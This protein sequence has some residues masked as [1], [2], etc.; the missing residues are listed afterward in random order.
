MKG[1]KMRLLAAVLC[2]I[3]AVVWA[4]V[5]V[6]HGVNGSP[7]WL[8]GLN[9]LCTVIWCAACGMQVAYWKLGK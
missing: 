5:S 2:G 8:T 6:L 7:L 4:V 1:S 9:I 3:A